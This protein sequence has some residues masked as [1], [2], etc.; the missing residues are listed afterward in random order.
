MDCFVTGIE[1]L[2]RAAGIQQGRKV[3]ADRGFQGAKFFPRVKRG[4]VL[5]LW[6]E[7]E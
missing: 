4:F 5:R 3:P 6:L 2:F 7:I 1:I